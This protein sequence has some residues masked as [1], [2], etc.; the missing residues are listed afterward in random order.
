L[1]VV[2]ARSVRPVSEVC[3]RFEPLPA[4]LEERAL[5]QWA[6][7]DRRCRWSA[8][9]EASRTRLGNQGRLVVRPFRHRA[10]R[11]GHGRGRRP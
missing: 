6:S 8:V 5:P 4:N 10:S 7:A 9:I 3:H 1:P 11:P 2:K